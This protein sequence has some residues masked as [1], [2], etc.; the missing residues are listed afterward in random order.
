M[1]LKTL[2]NPKPKII[3]YFVLFSVIFLC[4]PIIRNN[5]FELN[6]HLGYSAW[7]FYILSAIIVPLHA[8][9]LNNLIYKSV[10]ARR[11]KSLVHCDLKLGYIK[12]L[13]AL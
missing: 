7:L 4:L 9:G 2:I 1:L 11:S 12:L 6:N 13:L 10:Q 5:S 8:F 3:V